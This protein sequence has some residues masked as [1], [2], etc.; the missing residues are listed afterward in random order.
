MRDKISIG[1]GA[2][3]FRGE[4]VLVIKR[5]KPPFLDQWSIPGGGLHYGERLLDAVARE[6]REETGVEISILGLLDVFEAPPFEAD[7]EILNHTLL[8]DYIADW[9]SGEV[10]AGDDAAAAEFVSFEEAQQRL[11]WN[12]TRQAVAR[13]AEWRARFRQRP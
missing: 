8:I 7:G 11:S 12:V 4:E 9:V 10:V 2:V 6:V 3:V 13:A 1:V 5:G